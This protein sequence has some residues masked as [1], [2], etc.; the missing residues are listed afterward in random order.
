MLQSIVRSVSDKAH[1]AEFDLLSPAKNPRISIRS[2]SVDDIPKIYELIDRNVSFPV[3]PP[4]VMRFA[5]AINRN[6]I[7]V[8]CRHGEVV[9]LYAMLM[10]TASGLEALLLG[11]FD[12]LNPRTAQLAARLEAPA[13]V[14]QWLAVAPGLAAE[15]I[16]AV[17]RFLRDPFYRGA[18]LY[19]RSASQSGVRISTA[20]GFEP[21]GG[22]RTRNLYRYLRLVNRAGLGEAASDSLPDAA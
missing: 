1:P 17:S 8:F 4:A 15:G 7:I 14:Y 22:A 13:A 20:L 9:G 6:N 5:M 3:A 2:A 21:V 12:G 11:E 16:P 18:N 10:L 19:M